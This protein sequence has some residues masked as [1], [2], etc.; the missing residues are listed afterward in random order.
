MF[1]WALVAPLP[2]EFLAGEVASFSVDGG[3]GGV[4]APALFSL[5]LLRLPGLG[6]GDRPRLSKGHKTVAWDVA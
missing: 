2:F 1:A 6:P 5:D 3:L 4:G